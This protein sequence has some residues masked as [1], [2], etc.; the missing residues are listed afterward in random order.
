MK[1]IKTTPHTPT[2]IS[3]E[4][5]GGNKTRI[6]AYPFEAGYAVTVAHPLRRLLLGSSVG[7]SPVALKIEGIAHEFDSLRGMM[8]DVT[9]FIANLKLVRFK[10]KDE[11]SQRVTV[12]YRFSGHKVIKGEDL[13]N[14]VVDIV[15][16]EQYIATINDNADF[17]FSLIIEKGIGYVASEDIR[18]LIPD[19]Y[20]PLDAFFSPVLKVT[21]NI[22]NVLQEDD[23]TFEKVILEIETDGQIDPVSAF[24]N[25]L[26][27]MQRQLSVF[28]GEW[29]IR[30][31]H[32]VSVDDDIE[33]KV[34]LQG[35]DTLGLSARSFN[36]LDRV[37]IKYVGEIVLMTENELKEVKNLGKKSTD[38]IKDKM[39]ELG[40]PI[41]DNLTPEF[42]AALQKKI[43]KIK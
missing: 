14:D 40:Y 34:L 42:R 11:S 29:N 17:H 30:N 35:I 24:N 18:G 32:E 8:E 27:V 39:A 15:T 4:D 16:P 1:M 5:L 22:E 13:S 33:C 7:Y 20:I 43:A 10:I 37:D 36:C 6:V 38:E 23:P 9:L 12:D 31:E 3:I 19:E 2:E 41:G 28:S 21:Y 25:A 26:N